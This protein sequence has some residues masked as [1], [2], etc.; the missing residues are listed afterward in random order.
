[1][2]W[3]LNSFGAKT[4]Q[5]DFVMYMWQEDGNHEI[6]VFSNELD[7]D[8]LI[9]WCKE[10]FGACNWQESHRRDGSDRIM[11]PFIFQSGEDAM[12]FRLTWEG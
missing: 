8:S 4:M 9:E 2:P 11:T 6:H 5:N 10:Q 7:R 3:P 12:A 1:M